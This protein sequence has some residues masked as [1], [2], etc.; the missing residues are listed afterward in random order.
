M[1][2]LERERGRERGR[3]PAV[4]VPCDVPIM[5]VTLYMLS[6][7]WT[8]KWLNAGE[9]KNDRKLMFYNLTWKLE[10]QSVLKANLT[11]AILRDLSIIRYSSF[12]KA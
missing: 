10:L 8:L 2:H 9:P 5:C 6:V 1:Q 7:M 4:S 12:K 11:L 3:F